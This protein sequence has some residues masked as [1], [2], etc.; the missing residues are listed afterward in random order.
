MT[1][2]YVG[3]RR[4]WSNQSKHYVVSSERVKIEREKIQR[5]GR[6]HKKIVL[7]ATKDVTSYW[8]LSSHGIPILHRACSHTHTHTHTHTQ[9]DTH[10]SNKHHIVT[11]HLYRKLHRKESIH[12]VV[13]WIYHHH[14][15]YGLKHAWSFNTPTIVWLALSSS[16]CCRPTR[17]HVCWWRRGPWIISG[18]WYSVSFIHPT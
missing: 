8:A 2:T 4:L 7:P 14:Q 12:Y 1:L 16:R 5:T 15:L 10:T 11:L 13:N 17:L 18:E 9:R 6:K 3:Q